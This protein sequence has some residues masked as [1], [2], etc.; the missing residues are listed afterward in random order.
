MTEFE[1]GKSTRTNKKYMIKVNDS[2][3]HFGDSRYAHYSDDKLPAKLQGIYETHHDPERRVNYRLRATLIK[4]K[5][6][7]YTANDINSPNY[8]SI[9]LLW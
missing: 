8:W 2:W 3:I 6:G 7:N 4:D 9:R 1:I 5:H